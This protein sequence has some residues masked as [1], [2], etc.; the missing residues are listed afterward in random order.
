MI[1]CTPPSRGIVKCTYTVRYL[2]KPMPLQVNRPISE[3]CWKVKGEGHDFIVEIWVR[4]LSQKGYYTTL[5]D[6]DTASGTCFGSQNWVD[7]PII[8]ARLLI[9]ENIVVDRMAMARL[10]SSVELRSRTKF[11]VLASCN[12]I[13]FHPRLV[14]HNRISRDGICQ[15][16][17]AIL[18]V[19]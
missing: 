11:A 16:P 8:R 2:P 14:N 10:P 9:R 7:L 12:S 3:K 17:G 18:P 13:L 19:F 1:K 6:S 15:S 4:T 5:W